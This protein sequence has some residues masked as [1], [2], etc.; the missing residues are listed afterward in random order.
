MAVLTLLL[1]KI[2]DLGSIVDAERYQE[3]LVTSDRCPDKEM[4]VS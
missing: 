1:A 2:S 3:L 4:A